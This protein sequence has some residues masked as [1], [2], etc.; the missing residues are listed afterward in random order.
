VEEVLAA[1]PSG[2][3]GD[4]N[5][6]G[7]RDAYDDE[8]VEIAN[9][10]SDSVGLRGIEL[11]VNGAVKYRF[12][13]TD[14]LPARGVLTVFGGGPAGTSRRVSGKR[15]GLGNSG[16]VVE[17]KAANGS[18]LATM[19]YHEASSAW[20]RV[21]VFDGA[22]VPHLDVSALPFSPGQCPDGRPWDARCESLVLEPDAG[23]SDA[24]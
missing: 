11:A 22:P 5:G 14:C 16:G 8:F 7:V 20:V 23:R 19:T 1:V 15:L 9:R 21:P 18:I 10:A 3:E 2:I 13:V 17:L 24:D 4:A 12:D 6:D